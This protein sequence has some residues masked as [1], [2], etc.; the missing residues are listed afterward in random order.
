[1]YSLRKKSPHLEF[2]LNFVL[3]HLFVSSSLPNFSHSVDVEHNVHSLDHD[4]SRWQGERYS[5]RQEGR[6]VVHGGWSVGRVS[7]IENTR[8][9]ATSSRKRRRTRVSRKERPVRW[10]ATSRKSRTTTTV[11]TT[12]TQLTKF[13]L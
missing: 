10:T 7:V 11:S 5:L 1:M 2:V 12:C 8:R 3:H 4:H 6:F 13:D 9:S